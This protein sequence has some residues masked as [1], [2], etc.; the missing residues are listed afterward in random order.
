M[1]KLLPLL[2]M[3]VMLVGC[4]GGKSN[5][6]NPELQNTHEAEI[7]AFEKKLEA[8]EDRLTELEKKVKPEVDKEMKIA[9]G[10]PYLGDAQLR[11][12]AKIVVMKSG[13]HEPRKSCDN[14]KES[15]NKL[16]QADRD[17]YNKA[18]DEWY[19]SL[20]VCLHCGSDLAKKGAKTCA[21]CAKDQREG[22][23]PTLPPGKQ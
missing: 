1:K 19:S 14:L 20:V 5:P 12:L 10:L 8:A 13:L 2:V 23:T 16:K 4:G 15:I 9:R 3:A 7:S 22:E 11:S 18:V 6:P 21:H 17:V